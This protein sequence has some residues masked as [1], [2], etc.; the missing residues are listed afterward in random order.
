[1]SLGDRVSHRACCFLSVPTSHGSVSKAM[2]SS[3][4]CS[5]T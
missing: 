4:L 3:E 2:K 5:L 1:M